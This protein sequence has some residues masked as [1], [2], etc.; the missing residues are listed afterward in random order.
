MRILYTF[1]S[2][3]PGGMERHV[4]DLVVGMTS[5]GH[6]VFVWCN[7]GPIVDW[8]RDAGAK[9][10]TKQIGF[11]VDIVY[12]QFLIKF[13]KDSNVDVVHAHELKAVTNS[14]IAG[15][16]ARTKVKISHTHT[17]ISE[18]KIGK[19]KKSVNV[20]GYSRLVN[21]LADSE[22]ALTDSR[23]RVKVK[24]GIKQ[25][26]LFVIPNGIDVEQFT[27]GETR[28]N[29]YKNDILSKYGVPSEKFIFGNVSRTTLEKDHETLIRAFDDLL[30]YKEVNSENVHLLIAG[31]GELEEN[32][33]KLVDELGLIGNVTITGQFPDEEKIKLYSAFDAFVFPSLAEGFG[34]VLIEA[35][36]MGLPAICSNLEVLEEVGGSAV[37]SYFEAGDYENLS[38]KM[39][40]L[41]MKRDRLENVSENAVERVRDKYSLEKFVNSYEDLYANFLER[42]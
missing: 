26:K 22:I 13:L 9:V 12:I 38:Q 7:E 14:L 30:Q 41:Y 35:M 3:N 8:Y 31:G 11:D 29:S 24:E 10:F 16:F 21:W 32:L 1:N 17:P 37:F 5:H 25:E 36:A 40:E 18:W 6:K 33:K 39:H 34:I 28:K 19:F 42:K 27:V 2:G 23:K 15:H 4:L 20:L